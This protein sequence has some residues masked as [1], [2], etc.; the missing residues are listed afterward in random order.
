MDFPEKVR[1][2]LADLPDAPGCYLMRD[3][4]G[5]IIYVGK[6]ASLRKRVQS[7]FRQATLRSGSPKV[8]GMV[9]SVEDLEWIVVRNEAEATL[10][11][12][13]LIKEFKPRYNVSFRDDKRFL[14]LR[15]NPA[16]PLP[17]LTLCR[18]ARDDGARY[19]G[20]YASS[21][22]ARATLDFTEK[23]YGLRKCSPPIPDAV[24]YKHCLNEIIAYCSALCIGKVTPEQYRERL[25]EACAF[26]RG[27]RP[28]VVREVR[29]KMVEAADR[30]D[31]E[32]AAALRDTYLLLQAAVRQ[33]ARVVATPAMKEQDASAGVEALGRVL[34]LARPPRVIEGFDISNT[35]GTQSVASM[36]CC[37]DGVPYRSRYRR[38]RIRTVEGIDDPRMMAEVIGRRFRRLL[39]EG[40]DAPDLVL[41]DGG[42]TQLRAARAELAKLGLSGVPV[43]GLAKRLEEIYWIESRPAIRLPP[44]S[45]ALKVL[46]RLRDEAH[47]F[48]LTYHRYLRSRRIRESALDDIPG[49]GKKRKQQ[50]LE[51]FGSVRRLAR[52]TIAEIAG[53]PGISEG[54]AKS[55]LN[56]VQ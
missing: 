11:E 20:P 39:D 3:R 56:A 55:I 4:V 34:G 40:S 1:R 43:A 26:L 51:R 41:V 32:G 54:L 6:A 49:I 16:D 17:R 42:I 27:E 50:I 48:A 24:T 13:R 30:R 25:D 2:R 38:F 53:V 23:R 10:T 36:V 47:R 9:R 44:D 29:D 31:F 33:N 37:L 46:Q 22:A 8:R 35:A 21:A 28:G 52:A 18:F 7:Y 5:R 15:V 19:F 12:G 45:P 14:L